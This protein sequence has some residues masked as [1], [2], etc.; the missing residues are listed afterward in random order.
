M[1]AVHK[2]VKEFVEQYFTDEPNASIN[3]CVRDAL[4]LDVPV[5]PSLVSDIRREYRLRASKQPKLA[6]VPTPAPVK[7]KP[8]FT[9]T[10][11]TQWPVEEVPEPKQTKQKSAAIMERR[12]Y[13]DDVLQEN[14]SLTVTQAMKRV[15]EKFGTSVDPVYAVQ[16]LRV[17]RELHAGAAK[18][19][20]QPQQK[21]EA[22]PKQKTLKD[23]LPADFF[24]TEKPAKEP[25]V[26]APTGSTK[27]ASEEYAIVYKT[28]K[29]ATA[30]TTILSPKSGVQAK[31][32]ELTAKG[33]DSATIRVFKQVQLKV[34]VTVDFGD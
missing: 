2:E 22:P 8:Q 12:Q 16:S 11:V 25:P 7:Q 14:P 26:A 31:L 6:L 1:G 10:W 24:K 19:A 29:D 33:V 4:E 20:T 30:L 34:K 21:L 32:M 13:Y 9:P 28:A 23:T 27:E 18:P 5:T 17:I 3:D 15:K